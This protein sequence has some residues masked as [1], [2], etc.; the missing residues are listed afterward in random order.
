MEQTR[1]RVRSFQDLVVWREA[2]ALSLAVYSTTRDFPKD[3]LYGIT[4]QL[5]RAAVSIPANIAEGSKRRGTADLRHF[6][7]IADS[8]NEEVKCLLILSHDLQYLPTTRFDALIA[9]CSRVGNLLFR[10]DNALAP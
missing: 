8:S 1:G 6:L 7:N 2:Y 3:E 9:Q 5:R 4:S 10:L